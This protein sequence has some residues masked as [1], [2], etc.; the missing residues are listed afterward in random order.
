MYFRKNKYFSIFSEEVDT[1]AA[2]VP[3]STE[4]SQNGDNSPVGEIMSL[5]SLQEMVCD[6]GPITFHKNT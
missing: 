6:Q 5:R 2:A 4:T 3:L 1:S